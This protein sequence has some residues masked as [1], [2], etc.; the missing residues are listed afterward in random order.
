MVAAAGTARTAVA[1]AA[2]CVAAILSGLVALGPLVETRRGYGDWIADADLADFARYSLS[3]RDMAAI[4]LSWVLNRPPAELAVF[5]NS[6]TVALGAADLGRGDSAFLNASMVNTGLNQASATLAA[7]AE[8]GRAPRVA[9]VNI[10]PIANNFWG[11]VRA[12]PAPYDRPDLIVADALAMARRGV[13]PRLWLRAVLD[14]TRLAVGV[15]GDDLKADNV[16]ARLS[17]LA[18]GAL[19]PPTRPDD[20]QRL[21][22]PGP[23]GE[24][25]KAAVLRTESPGRLIWV[26]PGERFLTLMRDRFRTYL[27]RLQDVQARHGTRIILV[28]PPV[29]PNSDAFVRAQANRWADEFRAGLRTDAAARGLEFHT[30]PLDVDDDGRTWGDCCHPP[31]AFLA[32]HLRQ[33]LGQRP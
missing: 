6:R 19:F 26:E 29:A 11:E 2:F 20:R 8:S 30:L 31:P 12:A 14:D 25:P 15:L 5:G 23:D 7:L 1:A 33:I 24:L 9:V 27:D 18:V 13:S 28:E 4:K 10:D 21:L 17:Y 16:R 3:T 22:P 32:R